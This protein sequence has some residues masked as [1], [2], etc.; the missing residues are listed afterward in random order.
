MSREDEKAGELYEAEEVVHTVFPSRDQSAE[1][2]HPGK[3][4]LHFP[5]P[6][7]SSEWSSILSLLFMIAAI[8]RDHLD[9]VLAQ[10][11]VQRSEISPGRAVGL[12]M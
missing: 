12:L 4:S 8:Q 3:Q 11:L 10:L 5:A 7:V 2:L 1:V 6:F 9:A